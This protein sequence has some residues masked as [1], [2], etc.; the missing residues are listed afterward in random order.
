MTDWGQVVWAVEAGYRHLDCAY[1]Y[2]NQDEVSS[3]PTYPAPPSAALSPALPSTNEARY[4]SV[5]L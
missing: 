5:P 4:R 3:A 1:V 2:R